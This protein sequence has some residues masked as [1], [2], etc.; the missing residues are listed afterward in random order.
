M[1][2]KKWLSVYNSIIR[3]KF[4]SYLASNESEIVNEID[5][6]YQKFVNDFDLNPNDEKVK[7]FGG[8]FL[9]GLSYLILVRTN[10]YLT[11]EF[12][13]SERCE[14][15]SIENWKQLGINDFNKILSNYNIDLITLRET[16]NG[17]YNYTNDSE[18]LEF[19]LGN[20]RH[21]LSHYNYENSDLRTI[22]LW[23]YYNGIMKMECE[24]PY[25]SFLNFSA[26]F[27]I[28]VNEGLKKINDK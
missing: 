23:N 5:K 1:N 21:S 8:H 20:I 16:N 22:R 12:T 19:F 26:D 6:E 10:E 25:S 27:G 13:I 14:I 15:L 24:I 11:K 9:M 17:G 4:Y 28:A 18:K 7:F 2:T 3:L